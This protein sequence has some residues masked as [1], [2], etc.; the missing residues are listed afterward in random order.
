MTGVMDM[1][2]EELYRLGRYYSWMNPQ[3]LECFLKAA[4]KGH[5]GSEFELGWMYEFGRGVDKS[6][7]EALR[8]Y[9]L[10][11]KHGHP[12]ADDKIRQ[13]LERTNIVIDIDCILRFIHS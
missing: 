8:W 12:L 1:N 6:E 4:E 7:E 5:A 10:A 9:R 2:P 3:S 13:I 11:A